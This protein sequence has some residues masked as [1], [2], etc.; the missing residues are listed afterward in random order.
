MRI[1]PRKE[2]YSVEIVLVNTYF[3]GNNTLFLSAYT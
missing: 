1:F 2:F 3:A